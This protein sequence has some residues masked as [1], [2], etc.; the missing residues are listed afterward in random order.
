VIKQV[1]SN[2]YIV[3][4]NIRREGEETTRMQHLKMNRKKKEFFSVYF[5]DVLKPLIKPIFQEFKPVDITTPC[6]N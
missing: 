2:V 4:K 5:L 1:V 3:D 6:N